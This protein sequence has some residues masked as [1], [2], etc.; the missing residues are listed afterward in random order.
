MR[1]EN[2]W[3]QSTTNCLQVKIYVWEDSVEKKKQLK[4]PSTAWIRLD[5]NQYSI[6]TA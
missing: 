2:R 5:I 6:R 1:P 3:F 4:S